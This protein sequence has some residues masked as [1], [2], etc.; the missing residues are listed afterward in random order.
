VENV[1]SERLKEMS[2]GELVRHALDEA[3][4]LARAEVLHARQELKEELARAKLTGALGAAA[5]VLA[6]SAVSVLFMAI[7]I[8]LPFKEAVGLLIVFGALLVIAAGCAFAAWR[9]LPKKPLPRTQGRIKKD[10][11]L[12]R[13]QFA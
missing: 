12:T 6:L 2:T 5:L 3:K 8:S 13:E 1:D 7:G 9:A 10:L 11:A 4:L